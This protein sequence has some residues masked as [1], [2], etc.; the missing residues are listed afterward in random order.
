MNATQR[1]KQAE[2]GAILSIITYV[3]LS[4]SKLVFGKLFFSQA[5]FAD[6]L[7]NL[8]DVLSSILVFVGLKIS[9]KPADKNHPYGNLR[10]LQVLLLLLLCVLSV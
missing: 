1:L 2:R 10:H 8:T 9:Q 4:T 6:G 5:L 3:L 7:N